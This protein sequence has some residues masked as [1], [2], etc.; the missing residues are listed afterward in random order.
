MKNGDKIEFAI[1]GMQED[2]YKVNYDIDFSKLNQEELE[3]QIEQRINVSAEPENI[4]ISMRVHLMNGAEEIA[5]QGVRAI[6]KVKPFNSF[7]NDMQEDDLKVSNPALIDT[8][9]CVCIGAI[10]GMLVKN[11]KGTPLDNVVLPLI[12]M[13]VIRANSTKRTK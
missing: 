9:I 2:S 8:F 11:L 5:M 6:F 7:V 3:F 1:V 10:R 13:N 12:P 4:I